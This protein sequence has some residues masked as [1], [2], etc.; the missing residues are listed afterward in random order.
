MLKPLVERRLA[1][2]RESHRTEE[3]SVRLKHISSHHNRTASPLFKFWKL[4]LV[5]YLLTSL[6]F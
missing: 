5:L 2:F 1:Q 3:P 4:S 6:F